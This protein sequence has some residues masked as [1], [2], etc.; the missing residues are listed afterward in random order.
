MSG[1]KLG[2]LAAYARH[3]RISSEAAARQLKRLNIDYLKPFDHEVVDRLR[4]NSRHLHRSQHTK[5]IP[6]LAGEDPQPSE[7]TDVTPTFLDSQ[8]KKEAFKAKLTEIEYLE[9]IGTLV[10]K[11]GVEKEWF[12]LARLVRD[13]MLNIP[14][15]VAGVVAAETDQRK[16]YD[17]LHM[18][19][20][21]ALE[22]I[23]ERATS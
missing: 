2:Y 21:K 11:E 13:N 22:G 14:A 3:A 1:T 20:C 18:E 15:R 6:G 17:M 5:P 4:Q 19:I 12:G 8:A 9:R 16:I 23:A 10:E 7:S